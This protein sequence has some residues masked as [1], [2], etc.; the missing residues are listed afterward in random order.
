MFREGDEQDKDGSRIKG[1]VSMRRVLSAVFALAAMGL[2][3]GGLFFSKAGWIAFIPGITCTT[4]SLAF[5]I[6]TTVGD[7]QALV[8]AWRGIQK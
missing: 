6:L 2:F 7:V 1:P 8:S 5:L 4:A 3:I